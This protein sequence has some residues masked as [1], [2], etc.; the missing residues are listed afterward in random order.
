MG[1]FF[2]RKEQEQNRKQL[3]NQSTV[4]E[5]VLWAQLKS[6]Q[7]GGRK[8]GRQY[9]VENY[10][11]DFYCTSEKLAI[12][13]DGQVHFNV[14]GARHDDERSEVLKKYGIRVLRYENK[15]IYHSIDSVLEDIKSNFTT[16]P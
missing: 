9:S 5:A 8:F 10:I 15:L 14:H 7:L 4:A 13:L 2:N 6:S 16:P 1:E 12:E 11:L 3:R